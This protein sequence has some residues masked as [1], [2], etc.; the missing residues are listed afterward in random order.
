MNELYQDID[1]ETFQS[2]YVDTERDDY[3]ILDVRE[4]FE[5]ENGHIPN[6]VNMPLSTINSNMDDIPQDKDVIIVCATGN[7]SAQLA[8]ALAP[9]GWENLYNLLDGT[10]GW[11]MRG[12]PTE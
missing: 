9:H 3:V 8:Q 2:D 11:I 1:I 10:M 4:E 7:R 5:F 6:A 12:L